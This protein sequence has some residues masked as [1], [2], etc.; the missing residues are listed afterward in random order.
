MSKTFLLSSNTASLTR[1]TPHTPAG[2][3]SRG[4][5]QPCRSPWLATGRSEAS[6][7]FDL[8]FSTPSY[9]SLGVLARFKACA[10]GVCGGGSSRAGWRLLGKMG[11]RRQRAGVF[12]LSERWT[13]FQEHLI[14]IVRQ[15]VTCLTSSTMFCPA[16]GTEFAK[17]ND[18]S[19]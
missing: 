12:A 9:P 7:S 14:G 2:S 16:A 10:A 8:S 19:G 3:C 5:S 4:S 6:G 11:P 15:D 17:F 13:C 18:N 1:S